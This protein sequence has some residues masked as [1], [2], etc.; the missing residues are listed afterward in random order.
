MPT[1]EQIQARAR[2][3]ASFKIRG[4]QKAAAPAAMREYR[5]AQQAAIDRMHELRALRLAREAE[6]ARQPDGK[7]GPSAR[8]G[9][10]GRR[11]K[12]HLHERF[13]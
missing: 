1:S 3:E 4:E 13:R 6:A 2:A 7:P 9:I 10:A 8:L 5:E 12:A 11:S